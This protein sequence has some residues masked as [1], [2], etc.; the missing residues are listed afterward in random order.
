MDPFDETFNIDLNSEANSTIKI[1]LTDISG[2]LIGTSQHNISKGN[3]VITINSS[4]DYSGIVIFKV[5]NGEKITT[6]KILK[7]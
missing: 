6:G 5:F 7:L 1:E 3:N 2:R 4:T